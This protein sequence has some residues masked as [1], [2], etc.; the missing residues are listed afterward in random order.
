M[1]IEYRNIPIRTQE[2]LLIK[3]R[4]AAE[5]YDGLQNVAKKAQLNTTQIYRILSA[6]GNPTL[7]NLLKIIEATDHRLVIKK[8]ALYKPN[9]GKFCTKTGKCMLTADGQAINGAE[10]SSMELMQTEVAALIYRHCLYMGD[11]EINRFINILRFLKWGS[12]IEV[13]FDDFINWLELYKRGTASGWADE[14][15]LSPESPTFFKK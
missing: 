3:L 6:E 12:P 13:V 11:N 5:F 15:I 10:L 2:E 8:K 1:D 9:P 7:S 14:A 4:D